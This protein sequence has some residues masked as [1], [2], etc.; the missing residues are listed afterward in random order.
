MI[1]PGTGKLA[2]EEGMALSAVFHGVLQAPKRVSLAW[3]VE[4]VL[5]QNLAHAANYKTCQV[6]SPWVALGQHLV[7]KLGWVMKLI[8]VV[9]LML[10][11]SLLLHS[12]LALV[13]RMILMVYSA[14]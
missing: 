2:M 3:L 13:L 9:A 7:A 6:S 11:L 12:L 5:P 8:I 14:V 4:Q 10:M 1:S